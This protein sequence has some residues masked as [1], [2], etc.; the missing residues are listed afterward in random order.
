MSRQ[1]KKP[2]SSRNSLSRALSILKRDLE[3]AALFFNL[4]M[5]ALQ[6]GAI[7]KKFRLKTS[8]KKC[9]HSNEGNSQQVVS[10]AEGDQK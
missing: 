5:R 6:Q 7:T 2:T 9:F 4:K 3:L 1:S 8:L 10:P